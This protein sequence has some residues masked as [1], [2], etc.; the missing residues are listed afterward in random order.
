[1]HN[2]AITTMNSTTVSHLYKTIVDRLT[3]TVGNGEARAMANLIVEAKIGIKRIDIAVNPDSTVTDITVQ[4]VD[5]VVN[6]V[7]AGEPL[8]YVLGFAWFHGLKLTVGPGVLIPRPETSQLVDIISDDWGSKPDLRV[9][10]VC[11]GSGAIA[12]ALGRT[13]NFPHMTAVD[14]S[15]AALNVARQNFSNLGI[16]VEVKQMD[17]LTSPLPDGPFDIIVS[18]PPYVDAGERADIDPR[19]IDYEPSE[20]LFV[21]DSDPTVFY[22]RITSQIA[23][24]LS[25]LSRGGR[26]YYEINPRH[27]NQVAR[28]MIESGLENVECLLDF[29]GKKRFMRAVKPI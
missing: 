5:K 10:D 14:I 25:L 9:L 28:Q 21:P 23:D 6:R 1:M 2:D 29:D 4:A 24:R 18:N 16:S 13:L 12:A 27:A 11:T 8:Q 26:L 20:A 7:V 15:S 19:V 17:V 3:P 22:R